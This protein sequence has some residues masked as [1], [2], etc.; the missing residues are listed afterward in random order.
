MIQDE[1]PVVILYCSLFILL[2]KCRFSKA[3]LVFLLTKISLQCAPWTPIWTQPTL[4]T[5]PQL[6]R[7]LPA[8]LTGFF[9]WLC[10]FS[11]ITH[12]FPVYKTIFLSIFLSYYLFRNTCTKNIQHNLQGCFMPLKKDLKAFPLSNAQFIPLFLVQSQVRLSLSSA[13]LLLLF[14]WPEAPF[15]PFL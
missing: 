4:T 1:N 8:I 9:L 14:P 3:L 10:C 15:S 2:L 13:F 5:G 7:G 6:L 11:T 12:T